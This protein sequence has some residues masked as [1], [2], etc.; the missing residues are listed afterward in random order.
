L[1]V[2]G[3]ADLFVPQADRLEATPVKGGRLIYFPLDLCFPL[4]LPGETP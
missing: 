1:S 2:A 4:D 3:G